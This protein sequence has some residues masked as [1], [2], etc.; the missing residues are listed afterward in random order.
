MKT[1]EEIKAKATRDREMRVYVDSAMVAALPTVNGTSTKVYTK[2]LTG[3]LDADATTNVAH[4]V[5]DVAKILSVT[6]M[7]YDD[8]QSVYCGADRY[9]GS[10][11]NRCYRLS[12]D[13]TNIIITQVGS[14]LQG[15]A[16]RIKIDYYL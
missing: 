3:T 12:Y 2:Y 13:A 9:I 16:Y 15:N 11:T 4:G 5:A 6:A 1:K 8:N 14:Y 7:C 10:D